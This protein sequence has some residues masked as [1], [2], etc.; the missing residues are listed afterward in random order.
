VLLPWLFEE[1]KW[2]V[3]AITKESGIEEVM[4]HTDN[5][6]IHNSAKAMKLLEEFQVT[7]SHPLYFPNFSPSG[8]WFFGWSKDLMQGHKF[9]GPDHVRVFILNVSHN[10]DPSHLIFV[11]DE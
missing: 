11:D 8:F 4:I 2:A 1:A 7:Q 6:K 3:I 5:C 9:H 10:L